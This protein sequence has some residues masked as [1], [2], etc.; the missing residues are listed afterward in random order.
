MGG[1]LLSELPLDSDYYSVISIASIVAALVVSLRFK[2]LNDRV[3]I[4]TMAVLL[5][6][7]KSTFAPFSV[8]ALFLILR[9][10]GFTLD[11]QGEPAS[12]PVKEDAGSPS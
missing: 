1:T 10:R 11:S 8:V 4:V 3:L 2:N 12:P 9:V 5:V 6:S 7:V